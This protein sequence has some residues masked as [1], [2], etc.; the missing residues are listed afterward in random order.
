M[1]LTLGRLFRNN[2]ISATMVCFLVT[3]AVC[4]NT[5][6][7]WSLL[8]ATSFGG[9]GDDGATAVKAASDGSQY[10]T[11]RFG[12]AIQ[13]GNT[14]LTSYGGEDIFLTKIDPSGAVL[15][16]IQAGGSSDDFGQALALDAADNIYVTGEFYKSAT[17]GS[18]DGNTLLANG[19]DYTLF[20]AKYSSSGVLAWVQTGVTACFPGCYNWGIGVAV[21]P[22]SGTVYLT[23]ISQTDTTFSSADGTYHTVPGIWNWHMSL[24]RY[25]TDGNFY[26]G[27]TNAASPNSMGIS[28]AVDKSGSAYVVG[29]LENQTTFYS[30]NGKNITITGF[31]P[32]QSDGNYPGDGYL[33][34]YDS[35][36]NAVWVNHFGG[37]IAHANAVAVSPAGDISLVGDIGNIDYGSPGEAVTI[38]S[39]QPPGHTV[40]LGGGDYTNP[41]NHDAIGVTYDD[42]GVLKKALRIGGP[43]EELA[44]GV[45]YDA[46]GLL[47]VSG[48]FQSPFNI[49]TRHLS[50]NNRQNLFLLQYSGSFLRQAATATDATVWPDWIG[51]GLAADSAGNL[52]VVGTYE[53]GALFGDIKLTSA[54]GLDM[55]LAEVAL[56]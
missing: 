20:L 40:N 50:G 44:N 22:T 21:E 10:I 37:Y 28:V 49:G 2:L 52:F 46:S 53:K 7:S 14:P 42:R 26:W 17:F 16:A 27:E 56:H 24:V 43:A 47:Y 12:S 9:S 36:G 48:F 45:T 18:T 35:S 33:V 54:G 3:T 38:V 32:G 11:G 55:F 19:V 51:S 13:F 5:P 8:R 6:A 15:W 4:A 41:Y 29:W 31:S 25:D 23:G 30:Q 39:S 34:K 1:K